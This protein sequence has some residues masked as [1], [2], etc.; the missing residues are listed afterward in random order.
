MLINLTELTNFATSEN[1]ILG[2]LEIILDDQSAII[3]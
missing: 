3:H 2:G 1:D